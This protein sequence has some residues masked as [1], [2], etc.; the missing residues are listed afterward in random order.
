MQRLAEFVY[1]DAKIEIT[2]EFLEELI[3]RSDDLKV[4]QSGVKYCRA[5]INAFEK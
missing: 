3:R 2:P 4:L 1:F 5:M